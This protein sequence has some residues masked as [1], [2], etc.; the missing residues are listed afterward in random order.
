MRS[1]WLGKEIAGYPEARADL[2]A[3]L[4]ILTTDPIVAAMQ[5]AGVDESMLSMFTGGGSPL[6]ANPDAPPDPLVT[7]ARRELAILKKAQRRE[8]A[9]E[10]D[11]FKFAGAFVAPSFLV[12][13]LVLQQSPG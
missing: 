7:S 1:V 9:A 4:E 5:A 3:A 6:A 12:F 2:E 10:R 11:G 13:V 8:K